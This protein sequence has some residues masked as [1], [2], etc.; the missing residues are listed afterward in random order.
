[1]GGGNQKA[2]AFKA[3]RL[4]DQKVLALTPP[5]KKYYFYQF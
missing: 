2:K 1:V 4:K 5:S 3:E